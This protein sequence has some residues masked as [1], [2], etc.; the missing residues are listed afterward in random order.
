M[1]RS[2]NRSRSFA[3]VTASVIRGF[4]AVVVVTTALVPVT[5]GPV[6]AQSSAGPKIVTTAK[7]QSPA[8]AGGLSLATVLVQNTGGAATSMPLAMTLTMPSGVALQSAVALP[9]TKWQCGATATGATCFLQSSTDSSSVALNNEDLTVAG[10]TF[11]IAPTVSLG[12]R[13]RVGVAV[14]APA[15]AGTPPDLTQA[16]ATITFAPLAAGLKTAIAVSDDI[17]GFTAGLPSSVTTTIRNLGPGT[18]GGSR[19]TITATGVMPPG[20]TAWTAAGT[21]WT[22]KDAGDLRCTWTGSTVAIGQ[23]VPALTIS[24]TAPTTVTVTGAPLS[25]TRTVSASPTGGGT[26]TVDT[27]T[28]DASVAAPSPP[29]VSLEAIVSSL[30]SVEA[31]ASAT[32]LLRTR[33][34]Q[35]VYPT[36]TVSI[37]L[38]LP[39]GF[40]YQTRTSTDAWTCTVAGREL[41][42]SR[43]ADYQQSTGSELTITL[44]ISPAATVGITPLSFRVSVPGEPQTTLADN[45]ATA[46]IQVTDRPTPA[47]TLRLWNYTGSTA[48]PYD[49]QPLALVAGRSTALGIDATNA[50]SAPIP[51]STDLTLTLDLPK[52][53]TTSTTTDNGSP[54]WSCSTTTLTDRS[55]LSCTVRTSV[56]IAI[57]GALPRLKAQLTVANSATDGPT[58]LSLA[59]GAS[60]MPTLAAAGTVTAVVSHEEAAAPK[61]TVFAEL[62]TAPRV[63]GRAGTFTVIVRNTGTLASPGAVTTVSL[64]LGLTAAAPVPAGCIQ[65]PRGPFGISV[66]CTTLTPIP[67]GAA[68]PPLVINVTASVLAAN[69]SLVTVSTLPYS[70]PAVAVTTRFSLP[71][72]PAL[73]AQGTATPS[74]VTNLPSGLPQPVV[75]LDG[76]ASSAIDATSAWTQT[77]LAGE[78]TVVFDSGGNG[79]IASFAAPVVVVAKTLHFQL[80]VSDG[81]TTSTA[82]VS[83]L[84]Q[85][86]PVVPPGGQTGWE[87][88]T[89]APAVAPAPVVANAFRL[90]GV[91]ANSLGLANALRQDQN[92]PQHRFARSPF[93]NWT[94]SP[95]LT[96]VVPQVQNLTLPIITG[97]PFLGQSLTASQG[98]WDQAVSSFSYQWLRCNFDAQTVCAA[99][100]GATNNFYFITVNDQTANGSV[101][102]VAVTANPAGVTAQSAPTGAVSANEPRNITPPSIVVP[103]AGVRVGTALSAVG[104]TWSRFPTIRATEYQWQCSGG[105]ATCPGGPIA[106]ATGSSFIPTANQL[107]G[108]IR[109]VETAL[110]SDTSASAN[111]NLVGPVLAATEGGGGS[112]TLC[113]L[114]TAVTSQGS[115][116]VDIS[117]SNP[118]LR[119]NFAN[120]TVTSTTCSRHRDRHHRRQH[121]AV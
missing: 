39:V 60:S 72:L 53:T 32:V 46:Q 79:R 115:G 91:G 93:R 92:A 80:T 40:A 67:A 109:V 30:A 95:L 6:F 51:A 4:V 83:V 103:A 111:S 23:T 12:A 49:G 120:A 108:Q 101:L 3:G 33:G 14:S 70:L 107:G 82:A 68:A 47:T 76:L 15:G 55:R 25:W 28:I 77:P 104:G 43:S 35:L 57:G 71:V 50:G 102:R 117:L 20:S 87:T 37:A 31:P 24:F 64:P 89:P 17:G 116:S 62:T 7:A 98:T 100:A 84:V 8:A 88:T 96:Q 99:I 63:G 90:F 73:S 69:P 10:L 19:S 118:H 44:G 13:L 119:L 29:E 54:A 36:R 45:N 22:C 38:T 113:R 58:S 59:L 81:T 114:L 106:G 41:T 61:I 16:S 18:L 85:P 97:N 78:P 65:F 66:A 34:Q 9:G 74:T 112:A 5:A 1:N 2:G 110:F 94:N 121:R 26:A 11:S 48:S 52:G 27:T 21:G 42:C 75:V 56:V 86:L 105:G